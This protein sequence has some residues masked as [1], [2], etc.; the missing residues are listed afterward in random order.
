MVGHSLHRIVYS[1][2]VDPGEQG[3]ERYSEQWH[4]LIDLNSHRPVTP[5]PRRHGAADAAL[6]AAGAVKATVAFAAS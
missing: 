6:A 2:C 5:I 4:A 3:L 1:W